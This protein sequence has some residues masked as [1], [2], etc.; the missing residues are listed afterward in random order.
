M[1]IVFIAK[2]FSRFGA[3]VSRL[4]REK[5]VELIPVVTGASGLTHLQGKST[6]LV[7][8]DEELEDMTGLEFINQ[9]VKVNPLVNT[10]LVG[11]LSEEEFHEKTEGLGVLLQLPRQPAEHDAETLLSVLDKI[12]GLL[13]SSTVQARL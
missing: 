1:T 6:D 5:H 11:A 4:R 7:I 8:V 2:D 10:A 9:L 13:Q 12:S 3:L